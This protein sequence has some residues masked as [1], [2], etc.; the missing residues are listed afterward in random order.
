MKELFRLYEQAANGNQE[1]MVF[2]LAFHAYCHGI[3]DLIDGD[4]EKN[5][6]NILDL[7]MQAN[8]LYTTPFYQA[9]FVRLGGIVA[10][11][12]NTYAD[13]VAW[14]KS[15]DAWKRG[16]ADVIRLCGND[17][18]LAV[19]A[20]TSGYRGMRNL[21]LKLREFSWKNQHQEVPNA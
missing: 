19:S 21:S 6:E 10:H 2:L 12:T 4:L 11:I 16:V 13:S 20:I 8:A 18:V 9:H 3:D 1:A 14:E 15:D 17:M 7:L 5:T